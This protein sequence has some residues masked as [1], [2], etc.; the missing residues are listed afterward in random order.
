MPEESLKTQKARQ[1]IKE[2]LIEKGYQVGEE[3]FFPCLNNMGE[4]IW[5]PYRADLVV[6]KTFIL[7]LDP[8]FHDSHIHSVKDD[9]RDQN[10]YREYEIKTARVNPDDI[11]DKKLIETILP[12]IEFQLKNPKYDAIEVKNKKRSHKKEK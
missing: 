12:D 4:V 9:H 5:P 8:L 6:R 10:I 2:L 1:K 3:E 7:E 11:L